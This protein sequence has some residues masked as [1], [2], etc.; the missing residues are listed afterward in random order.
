MMLRQFI[1]TAVQVQADVYGVEVLQLD[2]EAF[3]EYMRTNTLAAMVELS[4]FLQELPW[5]PWKDEGRPD[6]DAYRRAVVELAD[7]LI[8]VFNLAAA[9]G[10]TGDRLEQ[11]IVDKINVN[12]LRQVVRS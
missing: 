6:E 11:A 4:E 3:A 7:V 8:F 12:I 10:V 9:L 5:K 1:D 2:G